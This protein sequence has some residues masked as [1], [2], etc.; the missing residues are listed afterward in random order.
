MLVSRLP[1]EITEYFIILFAVFKQT[2]INFSLHPIWLLLFGFEGSNLKPS[3]N[4]PIA[5]LV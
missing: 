4:G 5:Q 1:T 3:Y 2:T